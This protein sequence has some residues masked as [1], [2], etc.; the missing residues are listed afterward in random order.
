MAFLEMK[1]RRLVRQETE[2]KRKDTGFS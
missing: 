1:G 2:R